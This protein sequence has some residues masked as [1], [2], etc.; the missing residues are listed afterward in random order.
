VAA[1]FKAGTVFVRSSSAIMGSKPT[2]GMDVCVSLFCVYVVLCVG[3]GLAT[4]WSPVQEVL[5]PVYRIK[6]WKSG[7]GPTIGLQ[8]DTDI[9]RFY[10]SSV[11]TSQVGDQ[12]NWNCQGDILR[13][14]TQ[15]EVAMS[16]FESS[17]LVFTATCAVCKNYT[18]L[19]TTKWYPQ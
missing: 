11:P 6:N 13:Y 2:R 7:Q 19:W 8:S 3:G 1:R 9:A 5:P 16:L 15:T 10:T 14:E 18:S 4:G 17:S 12:T